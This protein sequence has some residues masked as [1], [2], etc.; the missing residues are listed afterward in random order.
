MWQGLWLL[1]LWLVVVPALAEN[2]AGNSDAEARLLLDKM[3]EAGRTLDYDGVF[4]YRRNQHMD[5]M[6]IIH[7]SEAGRERERLISLSGPAREVIRNDESVTCIFPDD[8]SVRVE[9]SRPYQLL[10]SQFPSSVDKLSDSYVFRVAGSGRTAGRDARIVEIVPRDD[11][12][13]GYRLWLDE[14]S[15][16]LLKSELLN[17]DGRPIEQFMFTHLDIV[18]SIPDSLLEPTI[19]GTDYSWYENPDD[20]HEPASEDDWQPGWLPAGFSVTDRSHELL[21]DSPRPVHHMV[22]SDGLALVSVF[23]ERLS[24]QDAARVGP[25]KLGAVHAFARKTDDY[26]I[27]VVGEVP[28]ITVRKVADAVSQQP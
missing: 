15:H 23:I 10:S 7:K 25:S 4:V 12:R 17:E 20:S 28:A 1:G 11:F 21:A 24:E 8:H 6:R 27:M 14:K 13:Y 3:T 16:L 9:R 22:V 18:D 5:A 26:Q 2:G 19:N